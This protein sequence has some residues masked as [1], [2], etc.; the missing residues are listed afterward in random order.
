MRK[1]I[2]ILSFLTVF[3]SFSYSQTTYFDYPIKPDLI[4][5]SSNTILPM[6]GVFDVG[7]LGDAVYS[8]PIEVPAG[9]NAMQPSLSLTY[10]SFSGNGVCGLGF[11]IGGLSAISRVAGSYYYDDKTSDMVANTKYIALAMDGQRLITGSNGKYYIENDPNADISLVND[12]ITVKQNGKTLIYTKQ[13]INCPIYYLSTASD[14]FGNSI[15]YSYFQES[16][17]VYPSSITYGVGTGSVAISFVYEKRSDVVNSFNQVP[18]SV[19]KRLCRIDIKKNAALWRSYEL[20]YSNANGLSKITKITEKNSKGEQKFPAEFVWN[21]SK[22]SLNNT[23]GLAFPNSGSTIFKDIASISGDFDNDGID[24]IA[25]VETTSEPSAYCYKGGKDE[26]FQFYKKINL[27]EPN[28]FDSRQLKGFIKKQMIGNFVADIDGDGYKELIVP[29][30]NFAKNGSLHFYQILFCAYHIAL[31]RWS[32]FVFNVQ[33]ADIPAF[34]IGDFFNNG[35]ANIILMDKSATPSDYYDLQLRGYDGDGVDQDTTYYTLFLQGEPDKILNGDFDGDGLLDILVVAKNG[36]TIFWNRGMRAGNLFS[37]SNKTVLTYIKSGSAV[38][39]VGDFDGDGVTEI[40][41]NYDN[42]NTLY[43]VKNTGKRAFSQKDGFSLTEIKELNKGDDNLFVDVTDFNCDGKADL[44][45]SKTQG[46]I[47]YD[48]WLTFDG[49]KFCETKKQKWT[50]KDRPADYQFVSGDFNGDGYLEVMRLDVNNKWSMYK[51]FDTDSKGA[52]YNRITRIIENNNADISIIYGNLSDSKIYL[53]AKKH[54][55]PMVEVA[56]PLPVVASVSKSNGVASRLTK[57]Y[58]YGQLLTHLKGRGILGYEIRNIDIAELGRSV[59]TEIKEWNAKYFIPK[60]VSVSGTNVGFLNR[61]IEYAVTQTSGKRYFAYQS[62]ITEKDSYSNV[63]TTINEYDTKHGYIKSCKTIFN[64]KSYKLTSYQNYELFGGIYQP[65]LIVRE[66][67]HKDDS[68]NKYV[69]NSYFEYDKQK[70]VVI[71]SIENYNTTYALT[72]NYK[73]DTFGN[74]TEQSSYGNNAN[75]KITTSYTYDASSHRLV[76]QKKSSPLNTI[77]KLEYDNFDNLTAEID[78][79]DNN[80]Q[81]KTTYQ[82][83]A[84]GLNIGTIFP[85]GTK[86]SNVRGWSGTQ[87]FVAALGTAMPWTKTYYDNAGHITKEEKIGLSSVGGAQV[88]TTDYTYGKYDK[89]EK[90]VTKVDGYTETIT[91]KYDYEGRLTGHTDAAH[92]ISYIY[93]NKE[94]VTTDN[95]RKTISDYDDWGNLKKVTPPDNTSVSY[96]YFSSGKLKKMVGQGAV[97][98]YQYYPNGLTKTMQDIDAGTINYEYDV[99]G[100]LT[101]H[102]RGSTTTSYNYL[103]GLLSQSVCGSLVT[104]Y[105][106]DNRNRIKSIDNKTSSINYTYDKYDRLVTKSYVVDN[107]NFIYK[108][109]YNTNGLLAKKTFPDNSVEKYV[110]DGYGVHTETSL[111]NQSVWVLFANKYPKDGLHITEIMN[112]VYKDSYYNTDNTI[113][114]VKYS[115]PDG[116]SGSDRIDYTYDK[117]HNL[118]SRKGKYTDKETFKYDNTDR[119]IKINNNYEYKYDNNGNI[120]YQTGIGNYEYKAT[121]PHAVT[122]VDNET[123]VIKSLEQTVEYTSFRK[124]KKITDNSKR[125]SIK[126]YA[127]TYSPDNE[128]IKS[129]YTL[130]NKVVSTTYYLP[131]YEEETAKGVTTKRHYIYSDFGDLAAVNFRQGNKN[132]TFYA[133]TDNVGSVLKLVDNKVITKYEARYTPFGVRTIVKNNTGYNFPRGFTMHEHLDQFSLINANARLYDPYLA[134]FLSADPYLQDPENPQNFNR[135]S[136]CLNNPLKYTDPT[137][138]FV[139]WPIIAG[140][141]YGII[142]GGASSICNG[143][144][145][146]SG[147]WKGGIVGA[148]TSALSGFAPLGNSW[149]GATM[150][151]VCVGTASQAGMTWASGSKNYSN[152]WQGAVSGGIAGFLSSEHFQ[153]F[154]NRKGFLTNDQVL[155]NFKTGLYDIPEGSTWQQEVLNYFGMDAKYLARKPKGGEYVKSEG[156]YG[157]TNPETGQISIGNYAFESYDQLNFTYNK[158]LYHSLK[159]KNGIPFAK[160]NVD[161]VGISEFVRDELIYAPEDRL[162]FLHMYKNQGLCIKHGNNIISNIWAYTNKCFGM[163]DVVFKEKWWHFIYKIPRRW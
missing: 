105:T 8:V 82:Y 60:K 62:K 128:R 9:I 80:S 163:E 138:E 36:S 51:P 113:Q 102:T 159:I 53:S 4:S 96:T 31:N 63:T 143:K 83:D 141:I 24:D 88:I 124:P 116:G 39:L 134:R 12:K 156:F 94:I 56:Y 72:T 41:Y 84:W 17:F 104:T 86:R 151:G 120:L 13:N 50:A 49:N 55:Y 127:I 32:R 30:T 129:V 122:K 161:L 131:D 73:Y 85:D 139:W 46:N 145:F 150:W 16:N 126:K 48:Y 153:N 38:V 111:D 144:S 65:K 103:K 136:Y 154:S 23:K 95:G 115:S 146:W 22:N 100:R 87:Y 133:V 29:I 14:N 132:E 71:K 123:G 90:I 152:L 27:P 64:D 21:T 47:K 114:C 75:D 109:S 101:K 11:N 67:V 7:D 70:G 137:G 81:L 26:K 118:T 28:N 44:L 66:Q 158:E 112:H 79:T 68:K 33:S 119:L 117:Y 76:L 142:S 110:Y 61:T 10:S 52:S 42:K 140:S 107:K 121:Q 155:E 43:V 74:L 25:F 45:V 130:N 91:N 34:S 106:Y 6:G 20:S 78:A 93:S 98:S 5:T 69:T 162:G 54:N 19:A 58:T 89:P 18:I 148:A 3:A 108:Y 149:Y 157:S 59:Y 160:Q 92:T 97:V 125:D 1:I 147:A 37:D 40:A 135:Y 2:G 57:K 77:T 15:S 35:C 99:F